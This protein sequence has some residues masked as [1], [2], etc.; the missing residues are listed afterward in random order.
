MILLARSTT[1]AGILR[2]IGRFYGGSSINLVQRDKD[3]LSVLYDVRNANGIIDG[4]AVQQNG[5]L[6]RF[7]KI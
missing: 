1:L 7:W 4:V 2:L 6:Y 3:G 5:N